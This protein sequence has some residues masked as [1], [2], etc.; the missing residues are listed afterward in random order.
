MTSYLVIELNAYLQSLY[1][2]NGPR[3]LYGSNKRNSRFYLA[4]IFLQKFRFRLRFSC[5]PAHFPLPE[6]K[7]NAKQ[8]FCVLHTKLTAPAVV[9]IYCVFLLRIMAESSKQHKKRR[10]CGY[11]IIIDVT[12]MTSSCCCHF[13]KL[14]A[15]LDKLMVECFVLTSVDKTSKF[16]EI[17]H[18]NSQNLITHSAVDGRNEIAHFT[19]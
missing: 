16:I 9:V 10:L 15:I 19:G 11:D 13:Q 14:K 1:L 6:M 7:Y 12:N 17:I 18:P 8:R 2:K 3:Y 5:S 4:S